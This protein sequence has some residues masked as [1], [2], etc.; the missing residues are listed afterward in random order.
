MSSRRACGNEQDGE[1]VAIDLVD[2]ERGSVQRHRPLLGDEFR[3]SMGGDDVEMRHAVEILARGQFR[4]AVDMAADEMAAKLVAD[5]Q[6][7]FFEG[8][9]SFRRAIGRRW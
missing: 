6:R 4:H 7:A 5:L 2:G 3:Q 1:G 8:K 9:F